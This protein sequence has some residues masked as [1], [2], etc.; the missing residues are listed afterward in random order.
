[1]IRTPQPEEK[2]V[3]T[4]ALRFQK[5]K[6]DIHR[7]LVEGLD[8]TRLNRINPDRL[9]R[10]VRELAVHRKAI[11][12]AAQRRI[13]RQAGHPLCNDPLA[14]NCALIVSMLGPEGWP[15]LLWCGERV[16]AVDSPIGE[17]LTESGAG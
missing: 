4:F 15:G 2:A 7:Q 11:C 16:E 5:L 3:K 10:E 1:M 12:V 6:S 17:H 9:R 14:R 13:A 8:L